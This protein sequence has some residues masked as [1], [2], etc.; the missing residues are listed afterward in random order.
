M[1]TWLASKRYYRTKI[2]YFFIFNHPLAQHNKSQLETPGCVSTSVY[3]V[4]GQRDVLSH[5]E[6]I[7]GNVPHALILQVTENSS[8]GKL[9][10]PTLSTPRGDKYY[11]QYRP[12]CEVCPRD[13]GKVVESLRG[14]LI[15]TKWPN[16]H[17][18]DQHA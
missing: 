18:F 5:T 8:H 1:D 3:P 9:V 13:H 11:N 2:K 17:L 4:R 16:S 14:I 15:N 12:Q 7:N 10:G 6:F